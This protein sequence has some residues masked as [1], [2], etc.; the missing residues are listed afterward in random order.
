[1]ILTSFFEP[2]YSSYIRDWS[3]G[4]KSWL[5]SAIYDHSTSLDIWYNANLSGII[6]NIKYIDYDKDID[7]MLLSCSEDQKLDNI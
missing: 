2:S 7:E 1:M 3:I 4:P 6:P 5:M